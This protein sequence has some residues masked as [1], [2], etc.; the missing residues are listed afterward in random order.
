MTVS[1]EL[2]ER[3][4]PCAAVVAGRVYP[5]GSPQ[6]EA[7]GHAWVDLV[8]EVA[9]TL[10]AFE[11][12]V[13]EPDSPD[14]YALSWCLWRFVHGYSGRGRHSAGSGADPGPDAGGD[15]LPGGEAPVAGA[16][17]GGAA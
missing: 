3:V 4:C 7:A 17:S 10:F 13:V 15:G 6:P 12:P 2:A 9:D 5:L 16:G 11:L 1:K 8:R 14:W